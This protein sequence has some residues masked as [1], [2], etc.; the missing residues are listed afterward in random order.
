MGSCATRCLIAGGCVEPRCAHCG[1][2]RDYYGTD[3]HASRPS[4]W[5]GASMD[6]HDFDVI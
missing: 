6:Y 3:E 5:R 4:C 1:V 2:P